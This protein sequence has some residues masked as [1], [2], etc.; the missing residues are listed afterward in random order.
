MRI[1]DLLLDGEVSPLRAPKPGSSGRL[2]DILES[3]E[4]DDV[5]GL[6]KGYKLSGRCICNAETQ[7]ICAE[8]YP[9]TAL[10]KAMRQACSAEAP[11]AALQVK[12]KKMLAMAKLPRVLSNMS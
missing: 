11:A 3:F 10:I 9:D 1:G 7:D 6:S 4:E 5:P 12:L 8:K 2:D